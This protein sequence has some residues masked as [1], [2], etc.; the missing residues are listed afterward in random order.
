M[1]HECSFFAQA[2][3]LFYAS[4]PWNERNATGSCNDVLEITVKQ[5]EPAVKLQR[6]PK[7]Y[8][9]GP[10]VKALDL[11]RVLTSENN[12]TDGC[13]A[14]LDVSDER[15]DENGGLEAFL[16]SCDNEFDGSGDDEDEEYDEIDDLGDCLYGPSANLN[17]NR[18]G[19]ASSTLTADLHAVDVLESI[20]NK[21]NDAL[22]NNPLAKLLNWQNQTNG[23]KSEVSCTDENELREVTDDDR[24]C[25]MLID[26]E[27]QTVH[28]YLAA[29]TELR[30]QLLSKTGSASNRDYQSKSNVIR[31]QV[32]ALVAAFLSIR[33]PDTSS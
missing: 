30:R 28:F 5:N 20:L 32:N 14:R 2:I 8:S 10:F 22:R 16:D 17:A 1:K 31:E 29:V 19:A 12:C 13:D 4:A 24:Y 27:A 3:M 33:Y 25:A 15:E 18:G 9:Y 26:S 6:G 23:S 21:A 7:S 11:C